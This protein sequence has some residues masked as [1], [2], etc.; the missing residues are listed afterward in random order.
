MDNSRDPAGALA[1]WRNW[2]RWRWLDPFAAGYR[3][4]DS[5]NQSVD[6]KTSSLNLRSGKVFGL[7]PLKTPMSDML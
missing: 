2:T 4:R 6:G 1:T 5:C 7:W 3:C